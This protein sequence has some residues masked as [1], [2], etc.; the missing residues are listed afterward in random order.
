MMKTLKCKYD[1]ASWITLPILDEE[2]VP[3]TIIIIN[4][5]QVVNCTNVVT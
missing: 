2:L 4:L 5:G 1:K 3:D